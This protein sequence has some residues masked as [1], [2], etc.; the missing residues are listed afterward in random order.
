MPWLPTSAKSK[1]LS[2]SLDPVAIHNPDT[3]GLFVHNIFPLLV[4]IRAVVVNGVACVGD[5]SDEAS[6]PRRCLADTGLV[7]TARC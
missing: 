7:C 4:E 1:V 2:F 3:S 5:S 6:D